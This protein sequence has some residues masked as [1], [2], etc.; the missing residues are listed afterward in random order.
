MV[1]NAW[2]LLTFDSLRAL[3]N[4]PSAGQTAIQIANYLT[5]DEIVGSAGGCKSAPLRLY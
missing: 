5:I 2:T 4:E 1:P 3:R